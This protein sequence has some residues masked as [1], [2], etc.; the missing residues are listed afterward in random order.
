MKKQTN[1][2]S[3]KVFV[4][5]FCFNFC[6]TYFQF[7]FFSFAEKEIG[8]L[9]DMTCPKSEREVTSVSELSDST[10]ITNQVDYIFRVWDLYTGIIFI[11]G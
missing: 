3:L 5:S 7:V 4:V 10:I 6:V 2:F 8:K 9:F 1:S 11:I